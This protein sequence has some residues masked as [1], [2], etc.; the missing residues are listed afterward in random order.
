MIT[1]HWNG[2]YWYKKDWTLRHH[3]RHWFVWLGGWEKSNGTGWEFTR[4]ST[5]KRRLSDPFP[6]HLL[7][8]RIAIH[9]S[10]GHIRLRRGMYLV[11]GRKR[12]GVRPVYVSPNGT[13]SQ[14]VSW[15]SGA[16]HEIIMASQTKE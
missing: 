4:Q 5:G 1:Y 14:A 13:P 15:Y 6:V 7:G 3:V 9:G 10:W 11:I 8:H 12:D 2:E 16:P